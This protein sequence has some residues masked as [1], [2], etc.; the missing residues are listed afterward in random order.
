MRTTLLVRGTKERVGFPEQAK[1]GRERPE[2]EA[3]NRPTAE[4]RRGGGSEIRDSLNQRFDYKNT[5]WN[6]PPSCD[7]SHS[8]M[9][10][11]SLYIYRSFYIA[12]Y[13][14][15][16]LSL[17]LS[18]SPSI[19]LYRCFC[20]RYPPYLIIYV[21]LCT[22]TCLSLYLSIPMFLSLELSVYLSSSL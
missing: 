5:S 18:L 20:L 11:L 6:G 3:Y 17:S 4:G 19:S 21:C 14:S 7:L 12:L 10:H 9:I 13:F 15:L 8:L 2:E 1:R 16:C 22:H